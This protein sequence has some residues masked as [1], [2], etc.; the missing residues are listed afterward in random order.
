MLQDS[1]QADILLS[2]I[3]R[4]PK[5]EQQTEVEQ[6]STGPAL[7]MPSPSQAHNGHAKATAAL[8]ASEKLQG[9]TAAAAPTPG[10][11]PAASAPLR[12]NAAMALEPLKDEDKVK[13]EE[14]AALRG[15]GSG[16]TLALARPLGKSDATGKSPQFFSF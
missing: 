11:H 2:H 8:K 14:E 12:V 15:G 5:N 13:G 4:I 9:P 1:R 3:L 7:P 6:C 10:G 16:L